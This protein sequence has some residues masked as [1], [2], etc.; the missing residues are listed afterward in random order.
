MKNFGV[1]LAILIFVGLVNFLILDEVLDAQIPFSVPIYP[2]AEVSKSTRYD[3]HGDNNYLLVDIQHIATGD[4]E[5][6]QHFYVAELEKMGWQLHTNVCWGDEYNITVDG[7]SYLFKIK[8]QVIE[9]KKTIINI[10][11]LGSSN[12]ISCDLHS[13]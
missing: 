12:R 13:P 4:P 2:S 6:V 3:D 11:L 5:A 7:Q 1:P 9:S 8:F 10:R